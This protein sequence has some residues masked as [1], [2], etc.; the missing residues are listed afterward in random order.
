MSS[1][2]PP[3]HC[4]RCDVS[5]TPAPDQWIF[6]ELC[7]ECFVEFDR[8]KTQGRFA[9][10]PEMFRAA[11]QEVLTAMRVT[12]PGAELAARPAVYYESAKDWIAAVG[13][14]LRS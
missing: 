11:P 13:K 2:F 5:Y 6:Y 7:G 9:G 12:D 8:Q 4:R 1:A 10:R 14:K 3:F